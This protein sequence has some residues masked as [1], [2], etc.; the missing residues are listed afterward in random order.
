MGMQ[1]SQWFHAQLQACA[2]CFLWAVEQM[3]PEHLYLAPRADRWPVA[4]LV[5]HL[6][7]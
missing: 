1:L 7:C 3:L 6:A 5:Y 4:R 2:E